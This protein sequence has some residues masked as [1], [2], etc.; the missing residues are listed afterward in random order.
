MCIRDRAC[1]EAAAGRP[2][3]PFTTH[4]FLSALDRS[5][6]TGPGTGWSPRPLVLRQAG[7]AVAAMPLYVKSHS[8]GEY[9]FDQGWACLLYTS[10]CV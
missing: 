8:Q 2:Y 10:R 1:P 9:I 3:D 7:R 4:R 6:S 5:A